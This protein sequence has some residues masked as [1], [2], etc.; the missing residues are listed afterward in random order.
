[1]VALALACT[2]FLYDLRERLKPGRVQIT[3][4]GHQPYLRVIEPL[5]G[6]DRVDFAMLHKTYGAARW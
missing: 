6:S 5:F 3:T 4:D 2:V 1:V